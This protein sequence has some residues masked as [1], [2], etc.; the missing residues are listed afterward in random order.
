MFKT[1]LVL[2]AM[3]MGA[4]AQAATYKVDLSVVKDSS[5]RALISEMCA[6]KIEVDPTKNV[7]EQVIRASNSGIKSAQ[8]IEVSRGSL[9]QTGGLEGDYLK[10]VYIVATD[11]FGVYKPAIYKAVTVTQFGKRGTNEL[12][13]F[14]VS[15]V[16][17][18]FLDSAELAED[19]ICERLTY[20]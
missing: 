10:R 1:S 11:G 5:Q 18:N 7:A 19:S 8:L 14:E 13:G 3:M 15:T 17:L 12:K 9:S 16:A 4:N 6:T 2:L 20:K